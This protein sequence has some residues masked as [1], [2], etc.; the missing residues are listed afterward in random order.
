MRENRGLLWGILT[1]GLV[2]MLAL[3][4]LVG[5]DVAS[6]KAVEAMNN[7]LEMTIE[8]VVSGSSVPNSVKGTGKQDSTQDIL[9]DYRA[10]LQSQN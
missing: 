5:G 4:I 6:K 7:K 10:Y 1:A 9:K 3:G 8:S 2:P